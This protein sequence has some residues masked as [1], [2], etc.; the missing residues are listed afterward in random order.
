MFND[1]QNDWRSD[2]L[3]HGDLGFENIV[4]HPRTAA[5]PFFYFV[6][7]EMAC[8]GD[9]AWDLATVVR[10]ALTAVMM[11][12]AVAAEFA[13]FRDAMAPPQEAAPRWRFWTAYA[14]ARGWDGRRADAE[15]ER[16]T[17]F[18]A[19]QIAWSIVERTRRSPRFDP[20]AIDVIEGALVVARDPRP[21]LRA[22]E[23]N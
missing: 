8:V 20:K 14:R 10:P 21:A 1:A 22:F 3:I 6:D 15:L 12:H 2:A 4:L 17:R 11:G 19:I 13:G 18:A 23:S 16:V 9:A 7:W 5:S